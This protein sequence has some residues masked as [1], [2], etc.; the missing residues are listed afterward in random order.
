MVLN[1]YGLQNSMESENL[2]YQSR[3]FRRRS[4]PS[5]CGTRGGETRAPI[6]RAA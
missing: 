2:P 1:F 4:Q 3:I 5:L 6:N